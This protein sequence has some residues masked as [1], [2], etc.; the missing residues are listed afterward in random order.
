M[1]N[2]AVLP[3]AA[4]EI[5]PLFDSFRPTHRHALPA[6]A[7]LS[8]QHRYSLWDA[9]ALVLSQ[10]LSQ[11]AL[12]LWR[13]DRR[14]ETISLLACFPT[15][16][17][18]PES[19]LPASDHLAEL[20]SG[21]LE[22]VAHV[23]CAHSSCPLEQTLWQ[24]GS[25]SGLT[26]PLAEGNEG[27]LMTL[28]FRE[29]WQWVAHHTPAVAAFASYLRDC[30]SLLPSLRDSPWWET[31]S[32]VPHLWRQPWRP[33]IIRSLYDLNEVLADLAECGRLVTPPAEPPPAA[34]I[35]RLAHRAGDLLARLENVY[36]DSRATFTVEELLSEAVLLVRGAYLLSLGSWP[37]CLAAA[38][39][40]PQPD[41]SSPTA[42]RHALMDW[43]LRAIDEEGQS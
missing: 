3:S 42:L 17:C 32:E 36:L 24:L 22:V 35:A 11:D 31:T 20:G 28:G 40:S 4:A 1:A 18:D 37:G 10:Q 39:H 8:T 6:E 2:P 27:L 19:V 41:E 34:Q 12:L 25:H 16:A 33:S 29:S 5:R 38:S 7:L 26:V 43:V 9:L 21:R 14:R 30:R 15:Y 13:L 23:H